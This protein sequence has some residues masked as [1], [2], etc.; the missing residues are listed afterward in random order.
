MRLAAV[1]ALLL[2]VVMRFG[3]RDVKR[4]HQPPLGAV[5][6][7]A[8]LQRAGRASVPFGAEAACARGN[9]PSVRTA[10]TSAS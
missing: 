10:C 8:I 7:L 2:D 4:I 3:F 9:A 6:N 5:D 1:H